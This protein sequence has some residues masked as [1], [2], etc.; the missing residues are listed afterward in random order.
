ML[1]G[2]KRT[3]T[4]GS[5]LL[6]LQEQV[7]HEGGAVQSGSNFTLRADVLYRRLNSGESSEKCLCAVCNTVTS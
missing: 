2:A 7:Y 6:F 5:A 3:F 1:I 4:A